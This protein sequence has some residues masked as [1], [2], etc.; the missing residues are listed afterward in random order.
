MGSDSAR[1]RLEEHLARCHRC[2]GESALT[3]PA[4]LCPVGSSLLALYETEQLLEAS[5]RPAGW[6]EQAA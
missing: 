4:A 1:V 3:A 6:P 2:G 5:R